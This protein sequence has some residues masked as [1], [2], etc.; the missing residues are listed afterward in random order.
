M[1]ERKLT[2]F[3]CQSCG[4]KLDPNAGMQFCDETC[5]YIEEQYQRALAPPAPLPKVLPANVIVGPWLRK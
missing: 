5:E 1:G 2:G 3:R 4:E